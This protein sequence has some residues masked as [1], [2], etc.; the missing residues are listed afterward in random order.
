[1]AEGG[2]IVGYQEQIGGESQRMGV[3]DMWDTL[4]MFCRCSISVGIVGRLV[5]L[6][7]SFVWYVQAFKYLHVWQSCVVHKW[8]WIH[9]DDKKGV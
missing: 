2:D 3:A 1:M 9:I 5:G 4:S 6:I 7:V 8:D